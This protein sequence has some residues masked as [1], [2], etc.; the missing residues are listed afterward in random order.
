[1]IKQALHEPKVRTAIESNLLRSGFLGL[2]THSSQ[3]SELSKAWRDTDA[4]CVCRAWICIEG[5]MNLKGRTRAKET[6]YASDLEAPAL[7]G[8]GVHPDDNF[9]SMVA[10]IEELQSCAQCV[11]TA[12]LRSLRKAFMRLTS[13]SEKTQATFT[14][15]SEP[16]F[17]IYCDANNDS[18][19]IVLGEQALL[20][21]KDKKLN[22]KEVAVS[23]QIVAW[24][25]QKMGNNSSL[26]GILHMALPAAERRGDSWESAEA[27]AKLMLRSVLT[28]RLTA[29]RP[30]STT[31]ERLENF[32]QTLER[33]VADRYV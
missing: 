18:F 13:S 23:R 11:Q 29:D 25:E 21:K 8:G 14:S 20:L 26:K 16:M 17:R 30:G 31:E 15:K 1:M 3:L 28:H 32:A 5:N 4:A 27:P 9:G 6:C 33:K 12:V 7:T 24:L 10:K 19:Q 22:E 2:P